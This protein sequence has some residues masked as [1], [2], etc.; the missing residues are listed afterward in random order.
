MRSIL[1]VIFSI[2]IVLP[3]FGKCGHALVVYPE[4]IEI[5][6]N[7]KI[8]LEGS[9]YGHYCEIFDKLD[10]TYPIFIQSGEH[11]VRLIKEEVIK[12]QFL[13]SQA[14]FK[15]EEELIDGRV[16]E[17]FVRNL[18][19]EDHNF[20]NLTRRYGNG[21]RGM[22]K[23]QAKTSPNSK[24]TTSL[25]TIK[26]QESKVIQ[27]GCGPSVETVFKLSTSNKNLQYLIAEI[28]DEN[29]GKTF[30]YYIIP[31]NVFLTVGHGMCAGPFRFK[32]NNSYKIR[33]GTKNEQD[34]IE[35]LDWRNCPN[36]W[37]STND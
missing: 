27:Y 2:F 12:G 21:K 33:F 35:W 28:L 25:N 13:W 5:D 22:I 18:S 7:G 37:N 1:V 19:L 31:E 9:G 15:M 32:N 20:L 16:Y 24:K 14:V 29:T 23:W 4:S 30:K 8:I 11:K 26:H 36:P 10:S 17:L 34:D 6:L 3:S